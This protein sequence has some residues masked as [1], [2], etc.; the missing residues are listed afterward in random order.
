M[1]GIVSRMHG[2]KGSRKLEYIEQSFRLITKTTFAQLQKEACSFWRLENSAFHLYD[3]SFNELMAG[4]SA[5]VENYF[6]QS[7]VKH[8]PSLYLARPDIER[9]TLL[10]QQR[11][12]IKIRP[13]MNANL[14]KSK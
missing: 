1:Q 7:L 10:P 5:C 13:D 4:D 3:E 6:R 2:E 8:T 9:V 12:A 11:T 14:S